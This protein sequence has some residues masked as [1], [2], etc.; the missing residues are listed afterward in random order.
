M[1]SSELLQCKI[2]VTEHHIPLNVESHGG[3]EFQE[4]TCSQ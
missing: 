1:K 3:Q 4:N 2:V